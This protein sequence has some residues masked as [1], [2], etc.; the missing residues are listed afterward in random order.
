M[1]AVPLMKLIDARVAYEG[2]KSV[3]A[4]SGASEVSYQIFPAQS[5]NN[6][7][8]IFN[9]NVPSLDTGLVRNA[10]Y[11]WQGTATF[12]GTPITGETNLLDGVAFGLSDSCADQ[13]I[14]NE[15]INIGNKSNSV[16]RSRCGVEL[17]RINAPTSLKAQYQSGAGGVMPDFATNFHP[18]INS[19]KNVLAQ[20][21]DVVESDQVASPRTDCLTIIA[22]APTTATISFD[23]YFPSVV[24]PLTQ[25]GIECPA[26]RKID[27]LLANLQLE[28]N[29]LAFFSID[30]SPAGLSLALSNFTFNTSEIW[31]QFVTPPPHSLSNTMSDDVYDYCETTIWTN[32]PQTV[33]AGA[34]NV[35]FNLQQISSNVIPDKLL[36]GVRPIQSLLPDGGAGLPRFYLPIQDG[37]VNL[38]FNNTTV[39]NSASNRQLYE[40]SLRNGLSQT[41]FPQFAGRNVSFDQTAP[42]DDLSDFILGGS[43]MVLS[44]ELDCQISSKGLC[45][46]AFSNWALTGSIQVSNQTDTAFQCELFVIAVTSGTFISNGRVIADTGLLSRDQ[47]IRSTESA[48]V[49]V[50]SRVF[51]QSLSNKEGYQGG[52]WGSFWSGLKSGLGKVL[53]VAEKVGQFIPVVGQATGIA[54]GL[55]GMGYDDEENC[56]GAVMDTSRRA[57]VNKKAMARSYMTRK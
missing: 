16:E 23:I 1:S 40:I 15:T 56:G 28:S 46:G 50:S 22:N 24:S 8:H 29:L 32:S 31:C 39:L 54:R 44:P 34:Q 27:V 7:K 37:G 51:H 52:S 20:Q 10:M 38:K 11:H 12:V 18:W 53:G 6:S 30:D 25:S 48:E 49:P 42:A 43:F 19:N 55:T 35:Q 36:I 9:V 21:Y 33:N 47:F 45:N 57:V 5:L 17:A 4:L 26:I 41:T 13:I 3:P 14:S 2:K